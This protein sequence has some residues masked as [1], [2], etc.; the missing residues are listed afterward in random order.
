MEFDIHK[1][2]FV[3]IQHLLGLLTYNNHFDLMKHFGLNLT[4]VT[5]C[6]FLLLFLVYCLAQ[7]FTAHS[8]HQRSID[9]RYCCSAE[10]CATQDVLELSL[11]NRIGCL[12]VFFK[13]SKRSFQK[14]LTGFSD[15]SRATKTTHLRSKKDRGHGWNIVAKDNR[16][17]DN[18]CHWSRSHLAR[19]PKHPRCPV[20]IWS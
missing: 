5:T 19:W 3:Y 2:S 14:Q 7:P 9:M 17:K 20:Y 6:S 4:S 12:A 10:L 13:L 8:R 11:H 18:T 16:Y 15:F 1:H